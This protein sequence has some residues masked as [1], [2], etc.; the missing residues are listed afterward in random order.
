MPKS[1]SRRGLLS[2]FGTLPVIIGECRAGESWQDRD[3]KEWDEKQI[4]RILTDSPWSRKVSASMDINRGGGGG[5]M[6]GGGRGGRGGGMVGGAG[7]MGDGGG[8]GGGRGR[9]GGGGGGGMEGG[10][11]APS[12]SV[13]VRWLT[14][15]PVQQ[16]LSREYNR[17]VPEIVP[18]SYVIGVFGL[19]GAMGRR[20]PDQLQKALKS[21]T[22]LKPKGRDEFPLDDINMGKTGDK[23]ALLFKFTAKDPVSADD[24]EVDFETKLGRLEFRCKFKPKDMMYGGKLAV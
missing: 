6:E 18:G 13:V 2:A 4:Q 16:A 22:H 12:V 7:G 1:L 17:P 14:A 8:G 10:S 5:D 9:G 15:L 11:R 21:S 19:P 20:D 3:F 24:K 23:L